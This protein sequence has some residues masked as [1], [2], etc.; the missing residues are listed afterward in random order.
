MWGG[1]SKWDM[2]GV[3]VCVVLRA[4]ALEPFQPPKV[5]R[6]PRA[7]A[8]AHSPRN[9]HGSLRFAAMWNQQGPG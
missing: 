8:K 9:I 2:G 7:G 4:P 5:I 6:E 3:Q 1:E